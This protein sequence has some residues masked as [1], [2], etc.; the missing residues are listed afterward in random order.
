MRQMAAWGDLTGILTDTGDLLMW[1][2]AQHGRLGLGTRAPGPVLAVLMVACG[3]WY[4]A[5][6]A[7]GGV[8]IHTFGRVASAGSWDTR[9]RTMRAEPACLQWR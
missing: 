9:I 7:E 4:A 8:S 5:A 2:G 6:R 3:S 1:G